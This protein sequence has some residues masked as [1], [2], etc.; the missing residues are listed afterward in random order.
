MMARV[1]P[2]LLRSFLRTASSFVRRLLQGEGY[3]RLLRCFRGRVGSAPLSS[4]MWQLIQGRE[5]L[6]S[7]DLD[8]RNSV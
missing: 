6:S 1:W 5:C 8:S 4:F 3:F 2:L 7:N